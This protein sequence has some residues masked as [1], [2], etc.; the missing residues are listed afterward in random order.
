[1]AM[2]S[3]TEADVGRPFFNEYYVVGLRAQ[4]LVVE[5]INYFG[6]VSTMAQLDSELPQSYTC[7]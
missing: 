7:I 5:L 3:H 4:S 1:M 6:N 2:G